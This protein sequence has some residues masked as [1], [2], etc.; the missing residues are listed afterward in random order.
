MASVGDI[1]GPEGAIA[2]RLKGY[3]P[4]PEQLAMAEAV[5]AS[6]KDSRPLMVEAGTGVG[7]SFAYL[8]PALLAATNNKG[9]KTRIVV[10]THTISL[11]E[12]LFQKDIPF[13]RSLWPNEFSAVLVKGRSN[14]LSRRRLQVAVD[15]AKATLFDDEA[16]RQ[17]A[18][19]EQ[20]AEHSRDGSLSDLDFRPLPAVWDLVQSDHGNCL[21][22]SC[23]HH[24][25]C[26]H[27][28]ARRRVWNADLLI[29][30]HSLFFSDLALREA[31]VSI[32][33]DYQIVIF[34]EGHTLEDS[35]ASH[36]GMQIS[37]GAVEFMLN[38][39]YNERTQKGLAIV[40]ELPELREGVQKVRYQA[41][42]F[43]D[44]LAEW[45]LRFGGANG[46]VRS[47]EIVINR[48]TQPLGSLGMLLR[49]HA[50]KIQKETER[51]EFT[52][53]AI[54]CNAIGAEIDDW[55]KQ[56]AE[57]SVY[58]IESSGRGRVVMASSPI[59]VGGRLREMIWAKTPRSIVASATLSTG[60]GAD[61]EFHRSRLGM[62]ENDVLAL[63]SPFDYP[64][65]ARLH[66]VRGLPDPGK[67]STAFEEAVLSLIPEYIEMTKG[68]AFVLFTSHRA[69]KT[70]A[71]RLGRW[72][73]ER[74]YPLIAQSD[75]TP[76]SKMVERFRATPHSVLFGTDSF[77]QG[78]D[79]RGDALQNVIITRLP[80]SV[81]DRPLVEARLDAIRERGGNP[82][83]DYSLPEAVLKLKQ[84]FGRLIRTRLDHGH[85]AILDPRVLTK[86]YG[87]R[88]LD[89]LPECPRE[90][91]QFDPR[92]WRT[93]A[94]RNHEQHPDECP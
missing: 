70:A 8:V 29:V 65:Q 92:Y 32:L 45:N 75:G 11:Q 13:L 81:P 69:L 27:Y 84:G 16:H 50:E 51:I 34:D 87:A 68:H 66:L 41:I 82:F 76:R 23:P 67:E 38:R 46:R 52:A 25:E 61:F 48:I 37:S 77:W 62:T 5:A 54:R 88:F 36:L 72:L 7:K 71:E 43:F 59:D 86:A 90:I 39:I 94:R 42:D 20:W 26:F 73:S 83:N 35:A 64:H 30:N 78:V 21:G 31:G 47:K 24:E 58:W 44:D 18:I 17:L 15:K 89:A 6:I 60:P 63:G 2:K 56:T 85:V 14:Y 10:S 93:P 19:I 4:R 57:D 79:V 53:L 55:L 28:A 74:R 3:E 12:Q 49:E 9:D 33:P 80:F 91:R 1:L 22:K 40:Y